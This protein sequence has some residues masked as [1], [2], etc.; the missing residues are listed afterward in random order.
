M[1]VSTEKA[2]WVDIFQSD[3]LTVFCRF[4]FIIHAIYLRNTVLHSYVLPKPFSLMLLY[5][6]WSHLKSGDVSP[7]DL[8]ETSVSLDS[9]ELVE[10][11]E[12]TTVVESTAAVEDVYLAVTEAVL[13]ADTAE[14]TGAVASSRA[15]W[16]RAAHWRF[17][18]L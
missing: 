6:H 3:Y 5:S 8:S 4:F 14:D 16:W 9:S 15:A 17:F 18:S 13:G 12:E 2:E 7:P 10:G 11:V 1:V